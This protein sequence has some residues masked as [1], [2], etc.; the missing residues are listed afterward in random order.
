MSTDILREGFEVWVKA[1][2]EERDYQYPHLLLSRDPITGDYQTTWVDSAWI[3]WKASRA[4]IVI[5]LPEE[6]DVGDTGQRMVMD[7]EE[8]R[9]AIQSV[10]VSVC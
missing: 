1:Y 9:A 6:D 2:A 10:G 5:A 7:S 8:V 4:A 3:G